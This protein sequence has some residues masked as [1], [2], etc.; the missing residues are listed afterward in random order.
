MLQA[1]SAVDGDFLALNGDWIVEPTRPAVI[2]ARR[3]GR[4]PA[5]EIT[6]HGRPESYGVVEFDGRTVRSIQEKPHIHVVTTDYINAGVYGLGETTFEDLRAAEAEGELAITTVLDDAYTSLRAISF[7]RFWLDFSHHWDILSVNSRVLDRRG[8][9]GGDPANRP[10]SATTH[11]RATV[12]DQTAIGADVRVRSGAAVLPGTGLSDNVK[13]GANA[14]V[15]NALVFSDATIGD[16]SIV[17]DCVGGENATI[18][19]NTTVEAV[20]PML[21][22]AARSTKTSGS[23][24]SSAT[25]PR[26]AVV[27]HSRREQHSAIMRP[28]S[29]AVTRADGSK[30]VRSSGGDSICG[31]IGYAGSESALP[32]L[33][34]GL[35]RLEY[36]GYDSA[37]IALGSGRLDITRKKV[38][39]SALEAV[40]PEHS[41]ATMGIGH[42][43]WSTHGEPTDLNAHPHTDEAGEVAV[44]HNGIIEN[45]DALREGLE[46]SGHTFTS[47]TDTE[48]VPH[49]VE[50]ELAPDR[51]LVDV[52][53]DVVD[54]LEGNYALAV[55]VAGRDG[56][57]V[58][59]SGN[60]LVLEFA[61]HGTFLASDVPAFV[62]HTRRASTPKT[63]TSFT[64]Q[65]AE[66]P[67][68][69]TARW[70]AATL[71]RSTGTPRPPR[72][73]ATTTI[74]SRRSTNSRRRSD[75]QFRGDLTK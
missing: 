54:R 66:R 2:N 68:T 38:E 36:R 12:S 42:M 30:T 59:R 49:L 43:R 23:A 64:S 27:S 6:R 74:C 67:P 37:G 13:I 63:A 69:P 5:I 25:T 29:P 61:E 71:R 39:L 75:R 21:S 3:E 60:P 14:V 53:E 72:R 10:S 26:S 4:D 58:T 65:T 55:V 34:E 7:G 31:I 28:L 11:E 44:V 47:D 73:A 9:T 48:V 45:Y 35:S 52:V 22:S 70:S 41:T 16:G 51:D 15:G 17:C 40:F 19:Q 1:E 24:A 57:V 18:G 46:A 32:I 33:R 8:S 20:R 56:I 50:E 62:E